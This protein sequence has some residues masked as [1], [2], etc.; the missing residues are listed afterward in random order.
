MRQVVLGALCLALVLGC[1]V[2]VQVTEQT[3]DMKK[4][5][6][7]VAVSGFN[8][9]NGYGDNINQTYLYQGRTQDGRPYYRGKTRTDRYIYH[10]KR[11]ADDTPSPRWLLGGA[12]DLHRTAS[13]NPNDGEGCENE[14]NVSSNAQ[15][16]P[17]GMVYVD[18]LWC[19]DRGHHHFQYVTISAI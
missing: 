8:C 12:P 4:A 1:A 18:W 15:D 14:F 6:E 13:L 11:C 19:G 10:D 16:V 9:V 3:G 17:T 7:R 2:R 5:P